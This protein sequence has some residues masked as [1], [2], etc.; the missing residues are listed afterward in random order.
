MFVGMGIGKW[1]MTYATEPHW[2][3]LIKMID[4]DA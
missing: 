1:L 4:T 3:T 2:D